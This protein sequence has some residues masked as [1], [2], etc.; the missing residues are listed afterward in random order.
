MPGWCAFTWRQTRTGRFHYWF[1][2][3]TPA[4]GSVNFYF[5]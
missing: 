3:T 4:W 2:V 1:L 5:I